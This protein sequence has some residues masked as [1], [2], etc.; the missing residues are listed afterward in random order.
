[1]TAA[2]TDPGTEADGGFRTDRH[3]MSASE[4]RITRFDLM[5]ALVISH[6]DVPS[7]T[8][9]GAS[10]ASDAAVGDDQLFVH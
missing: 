7:D 10:A 8:Y 6:L 1:M 4:A 2:I 9:L 5:G 3:A